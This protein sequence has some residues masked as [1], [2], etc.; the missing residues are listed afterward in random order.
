MSHKI[1]SISLYAS[2]LPL[3]ATAQNDPLQVAM[4]YTQEQA[5][6]LIA[7]LEGWENGTA[8]YQQ[9]SYGD[10]LQTVLTGRLAGQSPDI[11]NV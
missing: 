6:P 2:L 3:A 8:E 10:Y 1:L 5:A 11:Y 4:H 7:C 9:I